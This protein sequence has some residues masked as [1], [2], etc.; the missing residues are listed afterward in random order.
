M[1]SLT[2]TRLYAAV[3]AATLTGGTAQGAIVNAGAPG[4]DTNVV[5]KASSWTWTLGTGAEAGPNQCKFWKDFPTSPA[6]AAINPA[7]NQ[8]FNSNPLGA[9][10]KDLVFTFQH[11]AAPHPPEINPLP[12]PAAQVYAGRYTSV[13]SGEPVQKAGITIFPHGSHTDIYQWK[14]S[15]PSTGPNATI[16]SDTEHKNKVFA[17]PAWSYTPDVGTVVGSVQ[18]SY[19]TDPARS[20][21]ITAGPGSDTPP[22]QQFPTGKIRKEISGT[23]PFGASGESPTDYT[24]LATVGDPVTSEMTLAYLVGSPGSY[25]EGDLAMLNDFFNGGSNYFV[26]ML[27]DVSQ[28]VNLFL[29]VDLTQWLSF[30]TAF[31]AGDTFLFTDGVSPLLPGIEVSTAPFTLDPNTGFTSPGLWTGEAIAL[32]TVDGHNVP[33]PR[34]AVLLLSAIAAMGMIRRRCPAEAGVADLTHLPSSVLR[35]AASARRSHDG[36]ADRWPRS[37]A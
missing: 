34:T 32:G 12:N 4:V 13:V 8:P 27:F 18:A 15:V 22:D 11:M 26:P 21:T 19:P 28:A 9:Q 33:E 24:V 1:R 30:P 16:T 14:V 29:A 35:S 6:G 10:Q 5:C 17:G 23:L 7:T 37:G 2:V 25:T 3:V 20:G 31:S 36:N